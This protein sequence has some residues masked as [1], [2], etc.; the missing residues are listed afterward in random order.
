MTLRVG[1]DRISPLELATTDFC[2]IDLLDGI[3]KNELA[4]FNELED[5]GFHCGC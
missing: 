5:L 2:V 4:E 3:V 1:V